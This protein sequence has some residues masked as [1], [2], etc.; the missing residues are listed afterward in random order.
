MEEALESM[1]D[2]AASGVIN[3]GGDF[4]LPVFIHLDVF[5]EAILIFCGMVRVYLAAMDKPAPGKWDSWIW[6]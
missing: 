1:S 4:N 2:E 3:R 6:I 5:R